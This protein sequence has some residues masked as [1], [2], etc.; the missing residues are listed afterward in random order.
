MARILFKLRNVPEDEADE[1]RALLEEHGF[2][3]YETTAGPWGISAAALWLAEDAQYDEA[4]RLLDGYQAARAARQ[5]ALFEGAA[6]QTMWDSIKANP[7]RA[8][9]YLTV[10]AGIVYLS[11]MPFFKL[12]LP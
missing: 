6:R 5:R 4:K 10:I 9:I 12:G 11:L 3:Y 2:A 8:I 1:V 7:G